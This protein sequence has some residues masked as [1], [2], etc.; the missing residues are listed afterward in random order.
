MAERAC[1][2]R[3]SK[4]LN[5]VI[6]DVLGDT[7]V[8]AAAADVK[9]GTAREFKVDGLF[10]AIGHTRT[11]SCSGGKVELDEKGYVV[12]QEAHHDERPGVFARGTS[13]TPAYPPGRTG[14]RVG[15]HGGRMDAEKYLEGR[16]GSGP[17]GIDS[18]GATK[19]TATVRGSWLW[20]AVSYGPFKPRPHPEATAER[21]NPVSPV[22]NSAIVPGSG[23]AILA[24][25]ATTTSSLGRAT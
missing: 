14:R 15:L 17:S 5:T 9:K 3:R 18:R 23:V 6:D 2:T 1:D 4:Y 7:S 19:T 8:P 20:L 11:R 10:V 22:A 24:S 13:T 25:D 21:A 12:W 16:L